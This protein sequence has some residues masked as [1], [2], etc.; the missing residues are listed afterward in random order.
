MKLATQIIGVIALIL[1]TGLLNACHN[2]SKQRRCIDAGG[3]F[4]LNTS[5]S[6]RSMCIMGN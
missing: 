1:M 5:D 6:S 2:E 3:K 4:V